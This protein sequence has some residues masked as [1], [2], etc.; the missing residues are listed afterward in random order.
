MPLVTSR[1]MFKRAYG[2]Y[3]IGAFNVNNMEVIQ[4]IVEAAKE[5]QAANTPG[6]GRRS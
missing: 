2:K 4:G 3:A 1:K 5:E 6:I